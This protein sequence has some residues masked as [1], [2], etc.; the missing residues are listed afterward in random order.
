MMSFY[1]PFGCTTIL[2]FV[3]ALEPA[4]PNSVVQVLLR[5]G[6]QPPLLGGA[7]LLHEPCVVSILSLPV[8][9]YGPV[10][11]GSD[12]LVFNKLG[13]RPPPLLVLLRAILALVKMTIAHLL[14]DV[15]VFEGFLYLAVYTCLH[16][17]APKKPT[18]TKPER[19]WTRLGELEWYMWAKMV[20][21]PR[22][23]CGL[24]DPLILYTLSVVKSTD[25]Y[26]IKKVGPNYPPPL[27]PMFPDPWL[28]HPRLAC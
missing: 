14:M 21:V 8:F 10:R 12:L 16:G 17:V 27:V 7:V 25:I 6:F 26:R 18:H 3:F 22:V 20:I 11:F 23:L 28:A 1:L 15:V 13:I 19:S 9:R 24:S 2:A 5:P 4:I